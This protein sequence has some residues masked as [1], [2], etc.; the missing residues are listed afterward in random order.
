MN[1]LFHLFVTI[2]ESVLD[3]LF[4]KKD[5]IVTIEAMTMWQFLYGTATATKL[6]HPAIYASRAYKDP[7]VR[8]MILEMKYK[9]NKRLITLCASILCFSIER[10]GIEKAFLVP[11]PAHASRLS[12]YGFNQTSLLAKEVERISN[13]RYITKELLT[14]RTEQAIQK[15]KEKS[16]R[17]TLTHQSFTV[18]HPETLTT[19]PVIVLDDVITT[20]ATCLAAMGALKAA[21]VKQIISMA[22]AH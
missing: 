20:G 11:I 14:Y 1:R 4:P 6:P 12:E 15:H 8:E 13:G 2:F 18:T 17:L 10:L 7:M 19:Y 3:I 22:V 21:E 9:K 5:S 16:A